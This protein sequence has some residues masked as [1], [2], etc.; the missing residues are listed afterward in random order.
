MCY[1]RLEYQ[2]KIKKNLLTFNPRN[3][4][5]NPILVLIACI[6]IKT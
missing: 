4:V 5:Q 1:I 3:L 2:R 6:P